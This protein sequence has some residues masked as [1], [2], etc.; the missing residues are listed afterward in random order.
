M[1]DR[2]GGRLCIYPDRSD[3]QT[4]MDKSKR[5]QGFKDK[6]YFI[7][8]DTIEELAKKM[9][10][11]EENLKQ[12]IEKYQEA[13][14]TGV[15]EEFGRIHNLSIDFTNAPFYAV[16]TRPGLQV[17]LG[18]I[19]V[20]EDMQIVK[21]D[22]TSFDNLYAVGECADDGIFPLTAA[23][24]LS[25][26]SDKEQKIV[27]GLTEQRKIG[28]DT[29]TAKCIQGMGRKKIKK[30]IDTVSERNYNTIIDMVSEYIKRSI[31]I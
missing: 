4:A 24:D 30:Y 20:N 22:G 23:V 16:T 3:C 5:L 1:D 28:L 13:V 8:A 10:V 27:F 19:L 12:T 21:E 31:Q 18:G 25:Y 26:L 9:E 2:A 11:P 29:K 14:Q 15:D 17:S 7:E 6:G